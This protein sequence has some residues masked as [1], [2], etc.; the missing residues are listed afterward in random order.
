[1][2]QFISIENNFQQV[3]NLA[4]Q[5][6]NDNY[7]DMISQEQIDYML[8]LMYNPGRIQKDIE[9][10][11][12]WEFIKHNNEVIGYLAYVIKEDNRVFLSKIY[13]KSS[14][15]GLGL[16]KLS[17]NRVINYAQNN[18]CS[19]VYLTVNRGNEKGIRAYNKFGFEIIAEEDFD[20]G[21]GFIMDD[22]IF[23]YKL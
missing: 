15:Q 4:T 20:I 5:I 12:V 6:W 13:L 16:G 23:E 11:F 18:N 19:A 1:M 7:Q 17:L 22:Y 9:E 21:N 3:F 14:A 8:N 2:H 10:G